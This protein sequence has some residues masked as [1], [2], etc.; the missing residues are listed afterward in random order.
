LIWRTP[1]AISLL[2]G[3]IMG[4]MGYLSGP[5]LSSLALGACSST[6]S[7]VAYLMAPF[8]KLWKSLKTQAA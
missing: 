7:F 4:A 8:V 6:M 5:F 3:L 1:L 2:I